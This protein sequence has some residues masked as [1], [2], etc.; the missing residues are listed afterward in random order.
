MMRTVLDTAIVL[1]WALT[2]ALGLHVVNTIRALAADY[3]LRV[4]IEPAPPP[5]ITNP[6]WT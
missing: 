6:R 1:L 3:H 5:A 4:V 2:L